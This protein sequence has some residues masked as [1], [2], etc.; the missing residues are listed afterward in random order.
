M[1]AT[2]DVTIIGAGPYGLSIGACL[3]R[4][5]VDFRI[6][7]TPMQCWTQNM[8]EGMLLKSAGLSSTIYD[9]DHVFTLRRYCE[10]ERIEYA[11]MGIPVALKTFCDYGVAFQRRLVPNLVDKRVVNLD[12]HGD[13]FLVRLADG[14]G[15]TSRRVV[16]AAGLEN[17]RNVPAELGA[18]PRE[19]LSHS[20]EV[21]DLTRFRGQDV[22]VMGGGSS[23]VDIAALLMENGARP[24]LVARRPALDFNAEERWPRPLM[25]RLRHPMSGVGIGWG[26]K[27]TADVLPYVYPYLPVEVRRRHLARTLGPAAGWFMRDRLAAVPT[28]LGQRLRGAAPE[29]SGIKL[30]IYDA[31]GTRQTLRADHI[32]AA[33]GYVPDVSRM[34]FI[35]RQLLPSI[36]TVGTAPHLSASFQSSV[37]GLYFVGPAAAASFGPIM[38]FSLGACFTARRITSYLAPAPRT[39]RSTT[40]ARD[41]LPLEQ[42]S[43]EDI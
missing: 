33:T 30:E 43:R 4:R 7:G 22:V 18:L 9:P 10:D 3:R 27:L 6:Y 32:I 25:Q 23:A 8:P 31:S 29:D 38:R 13:G 39:A 34:P 19:L 5:G 2:T 36:K 26:N 14:Q 11:D 16:V 37:P 28:L 24:V 41:S 35:A 40:T 21:R 20:G 12:R 1:P 17:F 42:I 15:F